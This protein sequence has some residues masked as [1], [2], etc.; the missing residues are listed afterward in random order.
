MTV[1]NKTYVYIGF[2][3]MSI[4]AYLSSA[5]NLTTWYVFA[6]LISG[7]LFLLLSFKKPKPTKQ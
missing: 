6:L 7:L 1:H 3:L 5:K 4:G 2:I